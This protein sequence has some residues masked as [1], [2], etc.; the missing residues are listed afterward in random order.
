[1]GLQ[2][3][4]LL[5]TALVLSACL[6]AV[7]W[8]QDRSFKAA[9]RAGAAEQLRAVAYGLLG[10]VGER[11]G[12]LV[13]AA[14]LGEPR[15]SQPNSG[16]YAYLESSSGTTI[17]RS[18]SIVLSGSRLSERSPAGK[19]PAPGEQYFGFAARL[20]GEP[21]RFVLAYTVIWEALG[22]EVTFWVLADE[23]PYRSQIVAFR[24]DLAVG[25]LVAAV[26]FLAIQAIALRWG[27]YPVRR[28]ARRLRALEAGERGDVGDDFPRE[29]AALARNL[30]RFI[31]SEQANRD[32][33]RNAMD[34]LAHSLKTPLAVL[35]NALRE[36]S[37]KHARLFEEQVARME[38]TVAH[39]LSRAAAVRPTIS[40]QPLAMMPVAARISRALRR[41]YA[42]KCLDVQLVGEDKPPAEVR[43]DERDLME[44]LGNLLENAFKYGRARIRIS[45]SISPGAERDQPPSAVLLVEDDGP[46]IAADKRELVLRRGERADAESSGQGIGL[47]VVVEL[48]AFYG[49]GLTIGDSELG[50]AAVYLALPAASA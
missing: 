16:L 15:L 13:L 7:G 6:G 45:A 30:N 27:L 44:M 10:A 22:A 29:L 34:D 17:W 37:D 40:T 49:G 1:M 18:P 47:A 26:V 42:Q 41:A 14:E 23:A 33:H 3:R 39:Q 28:I 35:K 24:R 2:T 19:R 11:D 12:G 8:I 50:G 20:A 31:A 21:T 36:L 5:I 32:R 48:A 38:T 43:V 4:L 9:V 25:L 46:G